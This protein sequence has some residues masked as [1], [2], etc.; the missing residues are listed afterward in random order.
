M[1]INTT[2]SIFLMFE[3]LSRKPLNLRGGCA[4]YMESF[5]LTGTVRLIRNPL[6]CEIFIFGLY[7]KIHPGKVRSHL[8]EDG[9]P[10]QWNIF[11]SYNYKTG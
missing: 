5:I 9:I 8:H 1:A 2:M 7:E 3:I 4:G 10:L 11:Y 6:F